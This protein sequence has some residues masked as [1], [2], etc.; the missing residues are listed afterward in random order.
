MEHLQIR[1][2]TLEDSKVEP[3]A[4]PELKHK[5]TI[6]GLSMKVAIQ[7]DMTVEHKSGIDFIIE[8]DDKNLSAFFLTEN[9]MKGLIKAFEGALKKFEENK[10]NKN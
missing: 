1:I 9:L 2:Q 3:L 4:Y 10:A 5:N 7:E 8:L 6:R